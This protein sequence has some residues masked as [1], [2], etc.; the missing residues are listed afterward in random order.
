MSL[1]QQLETQFPHGTTET[2]VSTEGFADA[3]RS[4]AKLFN[5]KPKIQLMK[6][7]KMDSDANKAVER[8]IQIIQKHYANPTWVNKQ[9]LVTEPIAA[10]DI[11][12]NLTANNK[13]CETIQ[14]V[15]RVQKEMTGVLKNLNA[16]YQ[17]FQSE[18]EALDKKVLNAARTSDDAAEDA[19][20]KASVALDKIKMPDKRFQPKNASGFKNANI[21][22]DG[23]TVVTVHKPEPQPVDT[24]PPLSAADILEAGKI[25]LEIIDRKF[26]PSLA[27]LGIEVDSDDRRQALYD[28][29]HVD[30]F[31]DRI[32]IH[33][34]LDD[35]IFGALDYYDDPGLLRAL[36]AWVN[37]SIK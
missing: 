21:V 35:Y 5:K 11:T 19:A 15:R 16:A 6:D 22:L 18:I 9:T 30:N 23:K 1:R 26:L 14:D 20:L 28:S 31:Y 4:V 3:I 7:G 8:L 36:E 24:L 37:R 10:K 2:S 17:G 32:T 13:P 29:G 34:F 25:M 27:L 12:V 33:D